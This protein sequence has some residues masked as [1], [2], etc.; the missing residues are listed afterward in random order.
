VD[1]PLLA[2][3]RRRALL[4]GGP[5]AQTPMSDNMRQL[6]QLRWIAVVG[7]LVTI[8]AVHFGLGVKL[9]LAPMFAVVAALAMA[10]LAGAWL[11]PR[12]TVSN[13]EIL[14]ALLFDVACLTL[15]LYLS[16]GAANPFIAL[17]LLQVVLGA[18]LLERWAAW[19]LVAATCVCYLALTAYSRPLAYPSGLLLDRLALYAL[20]AGLCFALTSVLLALFI[21]RITRNLRARDAY[22]ADLRQQ[23]AEEDGIV[24]MGLFASGAAHEL[25]TPLSSISVILG[26]WRRM[27]PFRESAELAGELEEMQ[28]EVERCKAI[29][30]DILHAAGEPRGEAMNSTDACAFLEEV[31]GAWRQIHPTTDLEARCR[32]LDGVALAASPALR[33]AIWN[34][35]DN[36]AEVSPDEVMLA[37]AHGPDGLVVSV[38]DRGPGFAAAELTRVGKPFPSRKGPGHGMGLFLA[39]NLARRLGGRLEAANRPDGG[40]EVRLILPLAARRRVET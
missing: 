5:A 31:A 22:L 11:M 28:A 13:P 39:A 37:A 29:V 17:Y 2:L 26:D 3:T 12:H 1:T 27:P 7:Q 25:G 33:Q 20:G 24:R 9:P 6:V 35:L 18:I 30:T 21:T 4:Q 32:G 16:G 36:A 8:L 10:N 15:Q 14:L 40:A 23:A 19:I 34:I 38:A